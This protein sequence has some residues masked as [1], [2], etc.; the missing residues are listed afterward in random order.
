MAN[1]DSKWTQTD[2]KGNTTTVYAKSYDSNVSTKDT[3]TKYHRV[4]INKND[5]SKSTQFPLAF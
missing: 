5:A 1:Y 2:L 3:S 4:I